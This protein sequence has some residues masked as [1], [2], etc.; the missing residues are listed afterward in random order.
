MS[1]KSLIVSSQK[2][3][4]MGNIQTAAPTDLVNPT[5][6][7]NLKRTHQNQLCDPSWLVIHSPQTAALED[8]QCSSDDD[9]LAEFIV[10]EDAFADRGQGVNPNSN[11]IIRD[12]YNKNNAQL[13]Q[14]DHSGS[15]NIMG[16]A[17]DWVINTSSQQGTNT[18]GPN[19][20]SPVMDLVDMSKSLL[21][22][23]LRNLNEVSEKFAQDLFENDSWESPGYST[24]S[25]PAYSRSQKLARRE[26]QLSRVRNSNS[27]DLVQNNNSTSISSTENPMSS[28]IGPQ[29]LIG[30]PRA[31]STLVVF[32]QK[33][34]RALLFF[35][36]N[37]NCLQQ[38]VKQ[39]GA[40]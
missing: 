40:E 39:I 6:P 37:A 15:K 18:S 29:R 35:L 38:D 13:A 25:S 19:S 20:S 34:N 36:N 12:I 5:S 33:Y 10:I 27:A 30:H 24:S 28:S 11:A 3:T 17:T 26:I 4:T 31:T 2:Q 22:E 16:R 32:I 14:N 8:G 7:A 1:N 9:I 21:S 23:A